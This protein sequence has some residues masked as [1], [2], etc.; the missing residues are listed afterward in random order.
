ME[1]N[2]NQ[3]NPQDQNGNKMITVVVAIVALLA[4]GS[5]VYSSMNSNTDETSET[6][7][8]TEE[9][10]M[11]DEPVVMATPTPE[12]SLVREETTSDETMMP[13]DN[14]SVKVNPTDS[15]VDEDSQVKEFVVEGSNFKFEPNSI[16]VNKG[17]TVR[18]IFKN[19]GGMHDWKID[20]F[21]AST[22]VIQSGEEETIEFVADKAGTFEYY[23][24]VGAHRANGMVG[25]LIVK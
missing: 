1:E 18:I 23:C 5:L 22:K 13:K 4:V 7:V 11:E 19:V 2:S 21:N 24:S 15:M 10:M 8:T 20:E 14:D 6:I 9:T 17:D 16:T 3:T 25:D 12:D